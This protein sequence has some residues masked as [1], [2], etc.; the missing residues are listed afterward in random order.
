MTTLDIIILIVALSSAFMGWRKGIVLQLG[1]FAGI[2]A[3]V[4]ACRVGGD[5][6]TAL[7]QSSDPEVVTPG[8]HY[9]Y[10]VLARVILF[11]AGYFLIKI[12]ARFLR[13]VTHALHIGVVDRLAGALFSLFAWMMVL[14][15]A[16]NFWLVVKPQT[17][18]HRISH[19]GNGHAIETI[20]ALAPAALGWAMDCELFHLPESEG[21]PKGN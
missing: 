19:L 1:S 14:S 10:T 16:I 3:G 5:W 8:E 2:V 12:V 18:I 21:Q 7:L 9:F 15:L 13:G 4:V 17:D 20:T 6:L 11:I